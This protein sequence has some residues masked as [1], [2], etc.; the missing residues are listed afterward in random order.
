MSKVRKLPTTLT[1]GVT[2]SSMLVF[3]FCCFCRFSL[4]KLH[5]IPTFQ[6]DVLEIIS[7]LGLDD[8]SAIEE[9]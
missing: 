2:S 7:G 1:R 8:G 5:I 6:I 4:L 3:S 9:Q